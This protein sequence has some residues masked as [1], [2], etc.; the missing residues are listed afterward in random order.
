[1][2]NLLALDLGTKCGYAFGTADRL[3]MV[4]GVWKLH[5]DRFAGGGMRYLRFRQRLEEMLAVQPI[6]EVVFEEV[7]RHA[8]TDAAHVYG[9]L[10]ATLTA[11]CE[12]NNIPYQG[13]PVGTIKKFAT[14]KGNASKDDVIAA[15]RGWG[16]EPESDDE[17]DALALFH[18]HTDTDRAAPTPAVASTSALP[19]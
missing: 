13:V 3:F 15:V 8:A 4:S 1:M 5:Q 11:W 2:H 18:L 10:M 7:R 19:G 16:Y 14:G 12:Q 17:A 9:G 6:S